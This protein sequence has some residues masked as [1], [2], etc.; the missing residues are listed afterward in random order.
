MTKPLDTEVHTGAR[1]LRASFSGPAM[2]AAE[3]S[4]PRGEV[5]RVLQRT[6]A[7]QR[8]YLVLDEWNGYRFLNLRVWFRTP[9]GEWRPTRK[10]VT[11]RLNE[12]GPVIGTM[13]EAAK[14]LGV[15]LEQDAET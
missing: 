12:L 15:P 11:V 14:R 9:E 5:L 10:G 8:L 1:P 3:E 2:P 4:R 6:E 7:D 13:T